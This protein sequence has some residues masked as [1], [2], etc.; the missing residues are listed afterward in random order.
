MQLFKDKK[1]F[2]LVELIIV[3]AIVGVLVGVL[4]PQYVKYVASSRKEVCLANMDTIEREYL[5]SRIDSGEAAAESV[6][7]ELLLAHGAEPSNDSYTELCPA[8]GRI[9]IVY[10]EHTGLASLS[11]SEHGPIDLLT[12]ENAITLLVSTLQNN[13]AYIDYCNS[14]LTSSSSVMSI[15]SE[16]GTKDGVLN[17]IGSTINGLLKEFGVDTTK[18]SWR[19]YRK[20][21]DPSASGAKYNIFWTDTDVSTLSVGDTVSCTMYDTITGELTTGTVTV[22]TETTGSGSAAVTYNVINGG[23][24]VKSS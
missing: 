7:S 4:V 22:S 11:C 23:S 17:G 19:I 21:N 13:Q 6:M 15:N 16:A 3:I 10:D 2:S 9:S 8:G 12:G 24:F 18:S 14:K 5:I 20:G 1:G